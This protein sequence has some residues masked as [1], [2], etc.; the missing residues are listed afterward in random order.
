VLSEGGGKEG[1]E[2]KGKHF[3]YQPAIP[4]GDS[5]LST[6]GEKREV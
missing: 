2:K 1:G 3:P 4:G 5:V 6:K